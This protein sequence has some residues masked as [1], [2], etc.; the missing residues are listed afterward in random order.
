[1]INNNNYSILRKTHRTR[2]KE[3]KFELLKMYNNRFIHHIKQY[4]N[5]STD[6]TVFRKVIEYTFQPYIDLYNLLYISIS[7]CK[8]LSYSRKVSL[9]Y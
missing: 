6:L 4:K 1:M 3:R 7:H 5:T 8:M 9:I 2:L